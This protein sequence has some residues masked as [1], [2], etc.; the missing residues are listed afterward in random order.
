[1]QEEKERGTT[2]YH[3]DIPMGFDPMPIPD[4]NPLTVEGVELGKKLFYDPILSS[5]YNMSCAGCHLQ[6][7]AF[8]DTVP[9]S[10]GAHHE[11]I[12]TRNSPSLANVG[13][14]KALFS[15]G[16]V[17]SLELQVL[18]PMGE[19]SEMD[20]QIRDA[21]SRM[22]EIPEYVDLAKRAYDREIDPWV[23]THALAS[24]QRT[25]I[26]G[27]SPFD[28]YYYQGKEEAISQ[29]AKNGWK[30]F[31]ALNC[32]ACH[33]GFLFTGQGFFNIGLYEEYEDTGRGRLHDDPKDIGKFKVPS[34]RNVALTAP[35]MH[36]GSLETLDEVLDHFASG[37]KDHPNKSSLVRGF[38]LD[39][40]AR[41][42]L[43]AFLESLTD[44]NFIQNKEYRP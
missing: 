27:D 25:L 35:Y 3:L 41:G 24:F 19:K 33:S 39:S 36:D 8:A 7:Y 43:L 15:E 28:R 30:R 42:E 5:D 13:Y 44:K 40:V 32:N 1:M 26:S 21:V 4:D 6:E 22:K 29:A 23:I 2:P 9:I 11:H 31:Q 20:L 14:L 34:L 17:P 12:G 16:G 37:G 38:E 10:R 18:A